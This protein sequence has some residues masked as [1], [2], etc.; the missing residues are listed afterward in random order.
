M[1]P[2][3]L[4]TDSGDFGDSAEVVAMIEK[5]RGEQ[6]SLCDELERIAD[7]LPDGSIRQ[8][9]IHYSRALGPAI[10][11]WH[12][13]EEDVIFPMLA[14]RASDDPG[15]AATLEQ[16]KLDHYE[17]ECFAEEVQE[18]LLEF[19]SGELTIPVDAIGYMLRGF[20]ATRRR[21]MALER[22]V[23]RPLMEVLRTPAAGNA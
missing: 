9:C 12:R 16:L 23:L 1:S 22:E 4:V 5:V 3:R 14:A 2:L 6:L 19:G 10:A 13:F 7:S 8:T 20:F 21:H 17:D 18:A 11:R 15:L